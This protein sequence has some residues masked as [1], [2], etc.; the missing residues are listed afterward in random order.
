M[1]TRMVIEFEAEQ[2]YRSVLSAIE[3]YKARLHTAVERSRRLLV[4]FETKYGVD[5]ETFLSGW[6]AEDLER[7]D[8]EY[9]EWAGEAKLLAGL[10]EELG[11]LEQA[12]Y[13]LPGLP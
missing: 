10:E 7:G 1:T 8:L 11:E 2:G 5:T 6:T 13:E 12:R 9:V 4:S 3:A